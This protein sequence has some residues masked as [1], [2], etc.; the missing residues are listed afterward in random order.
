MCDLSHV[1]VG[2]VVRNEVINITKRTCKK[3]TMRVK[4]ALQVIKCEINHISSSR[5]CFRSVINSTKYFYADFSGC[6]RWQHLLLQSTPGCNSA[7]RI[8]KKA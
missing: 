8:A 4:A 5:V 2:G 6:D 3:N 7:T 1:N